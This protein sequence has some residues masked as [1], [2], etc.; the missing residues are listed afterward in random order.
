MIRLFLVSIFTLSLIQ[1]Q[2]WQLPDDYR[3]LTIT[4]VVIEG[5]TVSTLGWLPAKIQ[6]I[7]L[8]QKFD[9]SLLDE[10]KKLTAEAYNSAGYP[11]VL[12]ENVFMRKLPGAGQARLVVNINENVITRVEV[13]GTHRVRAVLEILDVEIGKPY[14]AVEMKQRVNRLFNADFFQRYFTRVSV[15]PYFIKGGGMILGVFVYEKKTTSL[16]VYAANA[17]A[18]QL[19]AGLL[20]SEPR[21]YGSRNRAEL[22]TDFVFFRQLSTWQGR[23]RLTDFYDREERN[24]IR[25]LLDLRYL[26]HKTT[27]QGVY[28]EPAMKQFE[29]DLNYGWHFDAKKWWPF[30]IAGGYQFDWRRIKGAGPTYHFMFGRFFMTNQSFE[31]YQAL[32][33]QL[34]L[35]WGY[36]VGRNSTARLE[37]QK[38]QIDLK[39]I[40][41]FKFNKY[42]WARLAGGYYTNNNFL[43]AFSTIASLPVY[44]VLSSEVANSIV[45]LFYRRNNLLLGPSIEYVYL[46]QR[47]YAAGGLSAI[48]LYRLLT[49][50]VDSGY[51]QVP[52]RELYANMSLRASI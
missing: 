33:N 14:N 16:S 21:V 24:R 42:F 18:A 50:E 47:S 48:V 43:P 51:R 31:I 34:D 20:A 15:N 8:S 9:K 25:Y 11:Y 19:A 46:G 37:S 45:K 7:F 26:S 27:D 2:S 49:F 30:Y 1:A 23:L 44:S 41:W 40:Y 4:D 38:E 3:D 28:L 10:A 12:L 36:A 5:Q 35:R 29:V 13:Q 22:T 32:A 17:G 52:E 6:A 39:A